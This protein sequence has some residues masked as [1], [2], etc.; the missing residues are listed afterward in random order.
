MT[1]EE[2]RRM[3]IRLANIDDALREGRLTP[4]ERSELEALSVTLSQR[5]FAS[6]LPMGW[7][8]RILAA[9]LFSLGLF[10][11][12]AGLKLLLWSWPLLVFFSPRIMGETFR[13]IARR[14][15]QSL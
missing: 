6:W 7:P 3:R 15:Q 13:P 10:G 12:L 4:E 2:Y 11:L 5:L 14:S 1:R 9:A 8:A